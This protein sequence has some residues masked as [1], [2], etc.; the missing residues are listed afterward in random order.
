MAVP[1]I[2]DPSPEELIINRLTVLVNQMDLL[3]R[4][5]CGEKSKSE[6]KK[7]IQENDARVRIAQAKATDNDPED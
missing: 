1:I 6:I 5:T 4:L 7:K 2:G 3:I